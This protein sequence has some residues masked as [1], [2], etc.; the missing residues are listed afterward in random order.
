MRKFGK[1]WKW[2]IKPYMSRYIAILALVVTII[3]IWCWV[4]NRTNVEAWKIPLAYGGDAWFGL[5]WAKAF[6]DGEVFPFLMKF[7][8][9]LNA[10]F[11]ANWND[12]PS[13]EEIIPASIG[14][15][16]RLSG[17]FVAS[18]IVMLL[19]HILAGL[20]FWW[21]GNSLKYKPGFIF[22]GAVLFAFSHYIFVRNLPHLS[23]A[24]YWHIPLFLL[25]TWWCFS[26]NEIMLGGKKWWISAA[27]AFVTGTLN[28]Y[29]SGMFL[30]FL[31]FAVLL[32]I[33]RRQWQDAK[34][35]FLLCAVTIFGFFLMNMDTFCAR[36]MFGANSGA[37]VREL[38]ALDTFGLKMPELFIPPN[39]HCWHWWAN[40][41]I[42]N[43]FALMPAR[44]EMGS[45]YLGIV[46]IV[47]LVWLGGVA[48]YR[49]LQGKVSDVPIQAWQVIWVLLYG[50]VGGINLLVG[51][52]GL[53]LFRGTN[54]YSIIILAIS[55]LFLVR[56]LSR[57]CPKKLAW[58]LGLGILALGLWDQLPPPRSDASI[59]QTEKI[60]DSDR[61]LVR[62]IE[63]TLPKES[64]I[65]QIPVMDFPESSPIHEMG[66]YEHFRPYLF[67]KHLRLSY[68]SN[69]GR[70]REG[71]QREVARLPP[72]EMASRLENYGFGAIYLNRKG[73]HDRGERIISGLKAV[74]KPVLA[75]SPLGDIV[76]IKLFPS[77][78]PALPGGTSLKEKK[79][80]RVFK[81]KNDNELSLGKGKDLV[82]H[83]GFE[84][85]YIAKGVTTKPAFLNANFSIEMVVKPSGSQVAYAGII[86]N[87]PGHNYY[88]GFVIQ[89]E[90]TNQ[91]VFTFGY[92]NG[93]EWA[94]GV[95]F[96]LPEGEWS[97]IAIVVDN[98]LV[99]SYVNSAV[100]SSTE[101]KGLIDNSDMPICVGNWFR[102][103]RPFNGQI[104]EVRILNHALT[105]KEIV[106]NW[107]K[108]QERFQLPK[109]TI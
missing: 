69:K 54:R 62:K 91:N 102:N 45:P 3:I 33:V 23:L 88:E 1:K 87:H 39:Y 61:A 38:I 24:F 60:I 19:A 55:L 70:P 43:Y 82:L 93:K 57:F 106:S 26:R 98:S 76:A 48:L 12:Y 65:F 103:D 63:S 96:E 22:S 67:S 78:T 109:R 34:V 28:V 77:K 47:G 84:G 49:L 66:D 5:A 15:L 2:W 9:H 58:P 97:Y 80:T 72:A 92:G 74:G 8:G 18:N 27:I 25:V 56:E 95:R 11:T 104:E 17:L 7:V 59:Y 68:G 53:I 30:Q 107:K 101:T 108:L 41:G 105:D 21:V 42:K 52:F 32:H 6:S 31:G 79:L 46:G 89:Q 20:S 64:M 10:P 40:L 14:W 71:W 85:G 90:G 50:L 13:I 86:G 81:K 16:G 75:E 94:P 4:Y 83:L 37:A 44:G 29:Y 36:F 35:V 100:I 51:T 99:K 73:Y